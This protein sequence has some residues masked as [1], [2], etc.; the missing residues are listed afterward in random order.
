MKF[1]IIIPVYNVEAWLRPCVDSVLGQ[2]FDDFELILVDDGSPDRCPEL[3]DE[4]AQKDN[5]VRVI[6]QNNQGQ[7]GARNTGIAAAQGEYV[8]CIDSDDYLINENVLELLAKKT[9]TKADIIHY[10]FV[11][12][13][14]RDGSI[15]PCRFS[16]DVPTEGRNLADI[17]CE[18]I[19]R[20]AYYNSAWSKIIRRQLLVDNDIQFETGIVGEDNEWY[21][22][23]VMVAQSL[24]LIDRPLYVYRR[25]A[26][27]TTTSATR[28][29]L[30]DQLHV[31][32]KWEALLKQ[33]ESDERVRIVRGSLAK[34]YCSAVIIYAGLSGVD[35]LYPELKRLSFL[36]GASKNKRVV[37]FRWVKF[38]V[39]L[40][41]LL[42][43]ISLFTKVRRPKT[44]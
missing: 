12:W 6:H 18:L 26:G 34:Q 2:T 7:A 22:H 10:K 37:I 16:Y 33:Y 36:L 17:Y 32:T 1:S 5:R 11:E 9:E 28:K 40:R 15:T 23:V 24:V 38:L 21:Y 8:M 31:L 3:C 14:E 35:D 13:L 29:N 4:F 43:A 25:R 42:T 41:G 27:S 19:D 39:G 30:V 44:A 20:D